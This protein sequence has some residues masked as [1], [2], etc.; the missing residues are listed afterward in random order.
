MSLD[1]IISNI[2]EHEK[3]IQVEKEQRET[4]HIQ[5]E[6][7]KMNLIINKEVLK[8]YLQR[9][10]DTVYL[11]KVNEVTKENC[12]L[13]ALLNEMFRMKS[14]YE[15][16]ISRITWSIDE[17][18][19]KQRNKQR[20]LNEE[21]KLI[22]N[23]ITD[24]EAQITKLNREIEKYIYDHN[25]RFTREVY[26]SLPKIDNLELYNEMCL[27]KDVLNGMTL[28]LE[29]QYNRNELISKEFNVFKSYLF[30]ESKTGIN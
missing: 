13:L 10:N 11:S 7:I 24:K 29:K 1:K 21:I 12:R 9:F 15:K 8:K 14:E 18:K 22:K 20:L 26:I 2:K 4:N 3:K 27:I 28:L 5:L 23:R 6:D 30:I 17:S 19:T 25:G 16:K